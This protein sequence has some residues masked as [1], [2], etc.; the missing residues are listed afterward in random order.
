MD[1]P[2]FA[3]YNIFGK[4]AA[5]IGPFLTHP[6]RQPR[7]VLSLILLFI[8]GAAVLTRSRTR[9]RWFTC[10]WSDAEKGRTRRQ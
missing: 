4:F 8:V 3:W 1:G 7:R 2:A 10:D 5:I 6:P 9:M